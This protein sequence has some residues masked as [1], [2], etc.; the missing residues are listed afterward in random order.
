[1]MTPRDADRMQAQ[2][3]R[4]MSADQKIDIAFEMWK[5]GQELNRSGRLL[6]NDKCDAGDK[7]TSSR[8]E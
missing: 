6:S 3:Y 1:M 5:F 7:P 8:D 2:I 4:T